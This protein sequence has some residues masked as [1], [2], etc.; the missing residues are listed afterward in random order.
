MK[1]CPASMCPLV[2]KDG[3]PWT[4]EYA[5]KCPGHDDL[6]SGG[7]PWWSMACSTGGIQGLVE[8]AADNEGRAHVVGPNQPRRGLAEPRSL[9]AP[10]PLCAAGRSR[11]GRSSARRVTP[12]R[13]ALI[14][15]WCCFDPGLGQEGSPESM[16]AFRK[17]AST[18]TCSRSLCRI[19]RELLKNSVGCHR[20]VAGRSRLYDPDD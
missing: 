5:A 17:A 12:W 3:S 20:I 6:K 10:R 9:T 19:R 7:C 8:E 14:R 2:A 11:R 1:E 13:A 18:K 4:G 15:A 16:A